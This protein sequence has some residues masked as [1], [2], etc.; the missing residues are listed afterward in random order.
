MEQP[1]ERSE[2]PGPN[3][4]RPR[5]G[6]RPLPLHLGL[7][8][9]AWQSSKAALPLLKAGLLPWKP[10]LAEAAGALR[11]RVAG[12][13]TDAFERAVEREVDR[14]YR[15]LLNGLQAYRAHPYRRTLSEPVAVWQEG[16]SRLLDYAPAGGLSGGDARPPVLVVPSLINRAY[17]L[18]LNE[19]TSLLRWLAERSV[20]PFL[21]DWDR[22]GAEERGFSLSDYVAGRLERALDQVIAQTGRKPHVIGYCM[23]GLLALA[24][25][26]RRGEDLG[27]LA[28]LATPWDFHAEQAAQAR[29]A[30]DS[31]ATLAPLMALQGELPVD[32]IQG[33]FASLDPLQVIRKFIAFSALAPDDPGAL[34]FVAVEDWLNDGVPLAAPV[35]RECLGDWYGSNVTAKGAWRIG[36]ESILP[37]RVSLPTLCILP[38]QDRIVP[39]A[40]AAALAQSLPAATVC[41][42]AVGHVGMIVSAVAERRVWRPLADWLANPG[43]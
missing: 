8:V 40:S 2:A 42:P 7:A 13:A 23:G 16:T 24:L 34:Q 33:L 15:S 28:L 4:P 14:R 19:Q 6:P 25:A 5:L 11:N 29:L 30:G 10:D 27:A 31:L 38:G 35:A 39:P 43:R 32:I 3:G 36:G 26:V 41:R 21:I 37:E 18:D 1:P 12:S 20:R 9:L 17:I 22:P